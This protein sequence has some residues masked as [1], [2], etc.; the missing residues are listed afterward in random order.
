[1]ATSLQPPSAVVQHRRDV[2]Q[3]LG[4]LGLDPTVHQPP[5]G[6]RIRPG[7]PARRSRRPAPR[8]STARPPAA[9]SGVG[10][11]LG[12]ATSASLRSSITGS[13]QWSGSASMSCSC[14][15]RPHRAPA[16]TGSPAAWSVSTLSTTRHDASTPSS[17]A[18]SSVS[19]SMR[20]AEQPLVR[21]R[22]AR[23]C[24]C[25]GTSSTFLPDEPSPGVLT[26]TPAAI[27]T[28]GCEL[29]AEVVGVDAAPLVLREHAV[30][31]PVQLH[32]HLGAR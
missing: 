17:R 16:R 6:A 22:L 26:R 19:P 32:A 20:V 8:A 13:C 7:R 3:H 18:N 11:R 4:G 21:R 14:S 5:V 23:W 30:R 1:M 9:R 25:R 10:M 24:R 27:A 12:R 29:E 2:G 28:R 31:R 15:R